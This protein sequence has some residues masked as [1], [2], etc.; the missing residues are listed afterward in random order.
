MTS[1]VFYTGQTNLAESAASTAGSEARG[2]FVKGVVTYTVTDDL[3][4]MPMSFAIR[5]SQRSPGEDRAHLG[6]DELDAAARAITTKLLF[7][8][9]PPSAAGQQEEANK[10]FFECGYK[11]HGANKNCALYVA[12]ERGAVCPS[13]GREMAA[14]V[15][16][17]SAGAGSP[18]GEDAMMCLLKDDLTVMPVPAS[19]LALARCTALYVL[20]SG[21]V[22]SAAA[23]H[24]RTVLMGH[25]E[26]IACC[27]SLSFD[28][29]II[30]D[31][32]FGYPQS[33]A[34]VEH[35][36]HS[37]LPRSSWLKSI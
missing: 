15:P 34:G 28:S 27:L 1:Q 21:A 16:R 36:P 37:C 5:G 10:R 22:V 23:L 29:T 20:T 2:G 18:S 33:L 30:I 32:R 25:K 24:E 31:T 9:A 8:P 14:E 4:V 6:Y 11:K 35:R 12:G 17:G 13:C 19:K 26:V 7:Q 3:A